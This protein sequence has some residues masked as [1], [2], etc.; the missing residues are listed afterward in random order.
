MLRL[1]LSSERLLNNNAWKRKSHTSDRD[2]SVFVPSTKVEKCN[3]YTSLAY[4]FRSSEPVI[5]NPELSFIGWLV[6]H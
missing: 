5:Q 2:T 3:S 6:D 4:C 1:Q